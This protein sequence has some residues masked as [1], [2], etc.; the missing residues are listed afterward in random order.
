ML[1]ASTVSRSV[2]WRVVEAGG[3]E[4]VALLSFVV[5]ARILAPDDFG[6]VAIATALVLVLQILLFTGLPDAMIQRPELDRQTID[7]AMASSLALGAFLL[8][9][10]VILAWPVSFALARPAFP[11]VFLALAP[12]L[13]FNAVSMPLHALLRRQ[14]DYRA[15]ALR[16]LVANGVS[17]VVGIA[18]GL[19]GAGFWSLVAIQW[20]QVLLGMILLI[21]FTGERPWRL[22][23]HRASLAS[24][25]PVARP[26]MVGGFCG[27]VGRRLDLVVVAYFADNH[28]V[29]LYFLITRLL[30]AV[31][32]VTQHS[33]SEL[34]LVMFSRLQDDPAMFQSGLRRAWRLATFGCLL[35]F[36]ALAAVAP[37]VVPLVFGVDWVQA[38]PPLQ[39]FALFAT[40]GA[41][42]MTLSSILVAAGHAALASRLSIATAFILVLVAAVAA[43]YG[44]VVLAIAMGCAQVVLL[45]PFLM[46]IQAR[47][48]PMSGRLLLDILPLLLAF[49]GLAWMG[50]V[51]PPVYGSLTEAAL[52]LTIFVIGMGVVGAF[53]LIEEIQ[54]FARRGAVARR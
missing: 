33:S 5:M 15:I 19:A 23:W 3:N 52:A 40:A 16:T 37:G 51:Y 53:V 22:S 20:V 48:A 8:L 18:L 34:G 50:T 46:A 9:V 39:I 13:L 32:A 12:T 27:E 28:Q 43:R 31:Q 24:L 30:R 44:L 29:G 36:G 7:T 2:F 4:I 42:T 35:G 45:G 6:A 49:A 10:A 1:N 54:M 25:L 21:Y 47:V 11:Q 26:V 41:L 14:M 17:V 38:V